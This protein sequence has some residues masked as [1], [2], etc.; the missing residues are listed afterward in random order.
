M[1]RSEFETITGLYPSEATYAVIERFYGESK[2]DKHDFCRAYQLNEDCLAERIQTA[3]NEKEQDREQSFESAMAHM[4]DRLKAQKS[5]AEKA[6]KEADSLRLQLDK[7]LNWKPAE[8]VGTNMK[9]SDYEKLADCAD[10]EISEEKAVRLISEW[11]GFMPDRIRI[12]NYTQTFEVNKYCK[13]RPKETFFREPRCYS[14]DWN[15]IRF[16]C[17]GVQWE[18]VNGELM[19]YED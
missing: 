13:I 17:A 15:Y 7:E 18:L 16:D 19:Q 11:F 14:T 5:E 8:R 6:K 12:L 4:V 9:Q 10:S 1:L 3:V 2:L